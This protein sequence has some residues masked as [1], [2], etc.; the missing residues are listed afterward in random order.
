MYIEKDH[1]PADSV[2]I[3]LF[4]QN[5]Q[6]I[7]SQRKPNLQM[8]VSGGGEL[9][10]LSDLSRIFI[11]ELRRFFDGEKESFSFVSDRSIVLSFYPTTFIL[12]YY[13]DNIYHFALPNEGIVVKKV[14]SESVFKIDN[15]NS[16]TKRFIVHNSGDQCRGDEF[17]IECGGI[18]HCCS[19][20]NEIFILMDKKILKIEKDPHSS[21]RY[22]SC[23]DHP[24]NYIITLVYEF[25]DCPVENFKPN[26]FFVFHDRIYMTFRN[27]IDHIMAGVIYPMNDEKIRLFCSHFKFFDNQSSCYYL[28]MDIVYSIGKFYLYF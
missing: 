24:N 15:N 16:T 27:D 26:S 25:K 5:F 21:A 6:E 4:F 18:T 2:Y 28:P 1:D 14:E 10:L 11:Y 9:F 22:I 20:D 12:D 17:Q 23:D 3:P 7:Q 8:Q 13:G 19:R